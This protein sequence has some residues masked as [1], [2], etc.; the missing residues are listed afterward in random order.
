MPF[1]M[2]SRGLLSKKGVKMAK[3]FVERWLLWECILWCGGDCYEKKVWKTIL[4]TGVHF[5]RPCDEQWLRWTYCLGKVRASDILCWETETGGWTICQPT[6]S[7]TLER[8]KQS[9]RQGRIF[10]L[11]KNVTNKEM[12]ENKVFCIKFKTSLKYSPDG[13][14]LHYAAI[15]L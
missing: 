2:V 13:A 9:W 1:W 3:H 7:V 12:V 6:Q 8:G 10:C 14:P 5:V 15:P 4:Y 11:P